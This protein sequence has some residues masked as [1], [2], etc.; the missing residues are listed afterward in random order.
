MLL[1]YCPYCG[2]ERPETE[3]QCGGEAHIARP[4]DPGQASEED[5]VEFLY[6]RTNTKGIAAERWRHTNGC[7]RFFNAVRDTVSDK[8]LKFYKAGETMPDLEAIAKEAGK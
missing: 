5:W 6:M 7:G 4:A 1:I 8:F 3:F 2:V